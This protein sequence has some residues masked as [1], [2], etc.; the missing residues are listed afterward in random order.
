MNTY[1]YIVLVVVCAGLGGCK[2]KKAAVG[3]FADLN[4]E[5]N[6]VEMN[7]NKLN[8]AE[9]K[10][11]MTLDASGMILSGHAGC[12]RMSGRIEH[13]EWPEN[14]IRFS[15]VIS[16]RM[17]CLDMRYEDEL[18]KTLDRIVRFEREEPGE[19]GAQAVAFY[20]TDGGKLLVIEKK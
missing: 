18:F 19:T 16:T 15:G 14:N 1:F 2:A 7:G 11:F 17:A 5:W 4:G 13:A 8:P 10:Q 12:N 6:I 20:G 9:T 3:A